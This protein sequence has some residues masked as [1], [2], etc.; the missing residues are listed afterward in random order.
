MFAFLVELSKSV[1]TLPSNIHLV[2]MLP[3]HHQHVMS[4][5]L[6][7]S[8][9]HHHQQQYHFTMNIE[10]IPTSTSTHHASTN[11]ET[12]PTSTLGLT[13]VCVSAGS[14]F[15]RGGQV[16]GPTLSAWEHRTIKI[17]THIAYHT[18]TTQ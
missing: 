16:F 14:S 8:T 7:T 4:P 1:W 12:M 11:I 13:S 3:F 15:P 5:S 18:C 9:P 6:S 17:H 2:T 10:T